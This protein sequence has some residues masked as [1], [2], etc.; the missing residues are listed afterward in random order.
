VGRDSALPLLAGVDWR[1][2]RLLHITFWGGVSVQRVIAVL[3]SDG[4]IVRERDVSPSALIG[5]TI[6]LGL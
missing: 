5:G 2:T 6:S 1:P 3:D 4:N